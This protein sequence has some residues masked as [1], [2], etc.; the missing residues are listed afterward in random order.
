MF[1]LQLECD[2]ARLVAAQTE[3]QVPVHEGTGAG[4][5]TEGPAE[6]SR[7]R[8]KEAGAKVERNGEEGK[9]RVT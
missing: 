8:D 2:L 9:N 6:V 4:Q 7:G 1:R 5:G 3:R